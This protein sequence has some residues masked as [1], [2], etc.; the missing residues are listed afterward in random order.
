MP[1]P[2]P[3]AFATFAGDTATIYKLA[4]SVLNSNE[5]V[6]VRLHVFTKRDIKCR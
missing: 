6:Q 3:S 1:L 2:A 5:D 4:R